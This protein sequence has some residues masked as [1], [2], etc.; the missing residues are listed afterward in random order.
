MKPAG[1]PKTLIGAR[2]VTLSPA[3][4]PIWALLLLVLM[5][6]YWCTVN[7]VLEEMVWRWFV[8]R[9][10][11]AIV[12]SRNTAALLAAA[13]FTLHHLVV[14]SAWL[15]PPATLGVNLTIFAAGGL[16][17]RLT[18]RHQSVLPACISHILADI[19]L[20]TLGLH[21]FF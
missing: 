14:V 3:R 1:Q 12:P 7:A 18:L 21:L 5:G 6:L 13:A 2:G 17:C 9:Q 15:G 4:F 16:W 19:A 20:V 10:L 8:L 11:Q